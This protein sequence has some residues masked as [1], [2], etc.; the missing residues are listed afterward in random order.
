MPAGSTS[1]IDWTQIK[2]NWR[3][4]WSSGGV[5]GKN[6]I[7]RFNGRTFYCTTDQ[8]YDQNLTGPEYGPGKILIGS[9]AFNR[10]EIA[11]VTWAV[12]NNSTVYA[13]STVQGN[14][15]LDNQAA[16][17]LYGSFQ[18]SEEHTSELQSH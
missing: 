7:V 6:D 4:E 12:S 16:S 3:G 1:A 14:P 5:Y 8:L 13:M 17:N 9:D 10:G 15:N 2:Y 11:P 18:R